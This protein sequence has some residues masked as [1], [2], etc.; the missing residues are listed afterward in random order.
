MHSE[1][2][3]QPGLQDQ[4]D[5]PAAWVGAA[6]VS[7]DYVIGSERAPRLHR[8]LMVLGPLGLALA[9]V[10]SLWSMSRKLDH[11][12]NI[13]VETIWVASEQLAIRTQIVDAELAPLASEV[14]V[15]ARLEDAAGGTHELGALE[16]VGPGLSQGVISVPE[17][18]PGASELVL[19]VSVPNAD[20][21]DE[22]VPVEIVS[23]RGV[24]SGRQVVSEN[25]LQWADDT[26]PQPEGVRI[27]LRPDGRLLAG[28]DNRLFVR[29]T[30]PSGQPWA[31]KPP[32]PATIQ[33]LLISGEFND[34]VGALDHPPVLYEGPVD[35]LGLASFH[36]V[37]SSDVVRFEVRLT[38]ETE[39]AQAAE[40]LAAE[41]AANGANT[42]DTDPQSAEVDPSEGP[43][44][45]QLPSEL[46]PGD[47]PPTTDTRYLSGPKRRLRF[48][49]HAGTVR[50]TA[51][52]DFAHPGDT[53]TIAVEA[54][55]ARKPVFVDVHGPAGA[56][57]DTMTPPLQVPQD[58]DWTVP[59][60]L[61][62][63][64]N[65]A[66]FVQFEAYQSMLRP[67]DS[68][69]IARIQLAPSGAQ[70]SASLRPLIDRQREQLSLPRV[71]REFEIG[72]ERAYLTHVQAQLDARVLDADAITRARAFLIGS[73]E[74]VVHGPPQSLNTRSREEQTLATFKRNWTLGIRWFL[75]G[76]GG[77]FILVMSTLVWRNQRRLEAQTSVALGLVAGGPS[78]LDEETY[79]DQSRAILQARRQMLAR[80]ML[81]VVFMIA[82]LLLTVAML[83]SLVWA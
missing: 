44:A 10:L 46:L 64:V 80:G 20:S 11:S 32:T 83:E 30:D 15:T 3:D 35:A 57:L 19:H 23:K 37:L 68:S 47:G 33:V 48:V 58:R 5:A 34:A 61:T 65:D 45:A 9:I 77:L 49:S 17:V 72:R 70:R 26:D 31:P 8:T 81:T 59:Q 76:G 79:E 78:P 1:N 74:A 27:D 53:I 12:V 25:M 41:A 54:L 28:F 67:E 6:G 38:G 73:L 18:A 40:A 82:T 56:W 42:S 60:Q 69:A 71:D 55:S 36:G 62:S 63:A 66:P 22:R 24:G 7:G 29:V 4:I 13:Q 14:E 43:A 16:L 2:D 50:I 39:I 21:F 52:T 75:L 51:T